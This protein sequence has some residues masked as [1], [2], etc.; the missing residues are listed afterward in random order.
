MTPILERSR[1]AQNGRSLFLFTAS[2][3]SERSSTMKDQSQPSPGR[4]SPPWHSRWQNKHAEPAKESAL[5]GHSAEPT[6]FDHFLEA[7]KRQMQPEG[8]ALH[9]AGMHRYLRTLLPQD[10]M[11]ADLVAGWQVLAQPSSD[12]PSAVLSR[13]QT[14]AEL[15]AIAAPLMSGLGTLT[16]A[17]RAWQAWLDASQE[18]TD[19][20]LAAIR[21]TF[22]RELVELQAAA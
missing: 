20:R 13:R 17:M 12:A 3:R 10:V 15:A 9:Q 5:E 18:S 2:A 11:L 16:G 19:P 7:A 14:C 4:G 6:A 1:G 22:V 21:A 8:R